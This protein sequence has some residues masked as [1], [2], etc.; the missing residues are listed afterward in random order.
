MIELEYSRERM[1]AD[2]HA[3]GQVRELSGLSDPRALA[4]FVTLEEARLRVRVRTPAE[5]LPALDAA[6]VARFP[7]IEPERL[8]RNL[9]APVKKAVGNAHKR[10]NQRAPDKWITVEVVVTG[11]GAFV[12]VADEGAGFDV[13][14][15]LAQ[16]REG[17][18]YFAHKGSGFRRYAQSTAVISF[19]DGGSTF[20][21][22]FQV[23]G[24]PGD[25]REASGSRSLD[26]PADANEHS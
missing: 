15:T 16:F 18:A 20:R 21:A 23:P 24:T 5:I 10:G 12:E 4:D 19:A 26:A 17:G 6:F 25:R 14:A 11:A 13:R 9:L 7:G 3:S 22:R 2:I 1:L 8:K